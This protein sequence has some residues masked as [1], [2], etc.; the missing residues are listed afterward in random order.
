MLTFDLTLYGVVYNI[1][2]HNLIYG[3]I[4]GNQYISKA[5]IVLGSST[6]AGIVHII[7]LMEQNTAIIFYYYAFQLRFSSAC[8]NPWYPYSRLKI[9][10]K[11]IAFR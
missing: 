1:R 5:G 11:T 6:M 9:L 2:F 10:S 4:K 7:S 8:A 3:A